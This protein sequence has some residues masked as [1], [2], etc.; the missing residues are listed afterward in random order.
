[1]TAKKA[2]K[3]KAKKKAGRPTKYKAT[4]PVDLLAHFK[5]KAAEDKFPTL[6]GFAVEIGVCRD[7][8][9]EWAS[10]H[11]AFSDAYKRTKDFQEVALVDGAMSGKFNP[12]FSIF[13]AKNVLGWRD[14]LAIDANVTTHEQALKELDE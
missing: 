14:A 3:K 4:Y 12:A 11:P 10:A 6:A 8:L 7:T 2:T 13:T 5:D 1:M 9:H